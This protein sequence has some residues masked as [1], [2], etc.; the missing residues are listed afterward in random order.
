MEIDV[1]KFFY[2]HIFCF[3]FQT[4]FNQMR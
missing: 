4:L 1:Q 3:G 2:F